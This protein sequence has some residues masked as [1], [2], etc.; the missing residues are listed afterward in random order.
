M[1]HPSAGVYISPMTNVTSIPLSLAEVSAGYLTS[2]MRDA[3]LLRGGEVVGFDSKVIGEGAGFLGE[4]V[5]MRLS[6]SPGSEDAPSSVILKIPTALKNRQVGQTLGVYE[7]EIRFYRE[8]QPRLPIRTPL[9]YFSA[10]D[11]DTD[12]EANLKAIKIMDKMPLWLIRLMLPLLNWVNGKKTWHFILVIE[13]LGEYRIGDQVNG[14]SID[15]AKQS[16]STMAHLHAAFWEREMLGEFPWLVPMAYAAKP[17]HMMFLQAVDQF[18]S[19]YAQQLTARDL[20]VIEWLRTHYFDLMKAASTL[21]GTLIHGDFRL[22]NLCFDEAADEVIL[23]DWQTL[24]IGMGGFDLGYFLS[25]MDASWGDDVMD[26]M[27]VHYH[28]GL[29]QHGVDVSLE[30]VRWSYQLGLLAVL[31]RLVPADFQDMLELAG[32]G[33]DIVSTWLERVFLRARNLDLDALLLPPR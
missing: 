17:S 28:S 30:R 26:E 31:H 4:V 22:D 15:E 13:H 8:L 19:A 2:A 27:I 7:R 9:H 11:T 18:T 33:N 1:A 14:C 5:D 24:G 10:M 32:R 6:F 20:E 16:L 29:V 25:A 23:F 21:P 12:P 3:G